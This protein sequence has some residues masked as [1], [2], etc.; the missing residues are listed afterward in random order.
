MKEEEEKVLLCTLRWERGGDGCCSITEIEKDDFGIH[1]IRVA[2]TWLPWSQPIQKISVPL[3]LELSC[4]DNQH[5]V[6]GP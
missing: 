2:L 1:K 6:N 5:V 4:E 3:I